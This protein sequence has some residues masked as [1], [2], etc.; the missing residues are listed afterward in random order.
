MRLPTDLVVLIPAKNEETALSVLLPELLQK[1]SRVI[2]VDNGSKDQTTKVAQ[3]AG[4]LVIKERRSGYGSACLA[5]LRYLA[6]HSINP[7]FICFFDGD[8][9]SDVTDIVKVAIP[10]LENRT[11]YCQGSRMLRPQARNSLTTVARIANRIFAKTLSVIWKQP[12]SD[13]GPLRVMR[14]DLLSEL[15]MRSKNY[16]WTIEMSSKILKK[17]GVPHLEVPVNYYPR[18]SG[19]SKISGNHIT[20]FKAGSVMIL[21]LIRVFLFWKP[22]N[23][24]VK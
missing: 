1:V 2:V 18:S 19:K 15:N 21:T 6:A 12:V 3:E 16:G 23:K 13:L 5:G 10:V 14:W 17:G 20:A 22:G 24:N 11:N 4:A 7:R 8:G 9:Q